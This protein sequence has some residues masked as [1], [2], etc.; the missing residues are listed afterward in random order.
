MAYLF[1]SLLLSEL[2]DNLRQ[3]FFSTLQH[4]AFVTFY[5]IYIFFKM[6]GLRESTTV[7]QYG[8]TAFRACFRQCLSIMQSA[9][10]VTAYNTLQWDLYFRN[11][12]L[13]L[14]NNTMGWALWSFFFFFL[15]KLIHNFQ[16]L[17]GFQGNLNV[18]MSVLL[19]KLVPQPQNCSNFERFCAVIRKQGLKVCFALRHFIYP[20]ASG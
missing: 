8:S 20:L 6:Y 1:S 14:T 7:G 19:L 12:Y 15:M 13:W 10:S 2:G 18:I 9:C 5:W 4:W 3:Y 11:L 16:M 17:N